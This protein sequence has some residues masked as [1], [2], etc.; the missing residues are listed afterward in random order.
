MVNSYDAPAKELLVAGPVTTTVR[1]ERTVTDAIHILAELTQVTCMFLLHS[2]LLITDSILCSFLVRQSLKK[3]FIIHKCVTD[4][5]NTDTR[6]GNDRTMIILNKIYS[7]TEDTLNFH[8][9]TNNT[10]LT[11]P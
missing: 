6:S 1:W 3:L 5:L 11:C 4:F 8:L 2:I 7:T 9:F 10:L